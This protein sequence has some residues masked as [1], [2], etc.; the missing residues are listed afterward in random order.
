MRNHKV[1]YGMAILL[2][3]VLAL[4]AWRMLGATEEE[5]SALQPLAVS[6]ETVKLVEKPATLPLS[7]TVEGLTSSI[8]SSRFSGQVTRVLVEDGQA[9]LA[10]LTQAYRLCQAA[11]A[12]GNAL[13]GG[14]RHLDAFDACRG[15]D[16]LC[17]HSWHAV[18]RAHP[19]IRIWK[20]F[21]PYFEKRNIHFYVNRLGFQIDE[22]FHEGHC[23]SAVAGDEHNEG[24]DE[25]FHFIKYMRVEEKRK[26]NP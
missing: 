20:T 25:M 12:G 11:H 26:E 23:L 2:A 24:L 5:T 1:R 9:Q 22:F 18:E 15:A 19:G 16:D 3:A 14:A 8:V 4:L 7:G 6:I 21:T 17:V 13:R 10:R